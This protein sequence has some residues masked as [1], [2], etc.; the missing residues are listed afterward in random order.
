MSN[1]Q[2]VKNTV[3]NP[4]L[5]KI[6]EIKNSG[7]EFKKLG[8]VGIFYSG[9]S[10][11]NKYDFINGNAKF[12]SY[13]NVFNNME[14][15]LNIN[16]TVKV[17][18][19]ES[20]N[21]IKYADVLFTG[22][23]ETLEESGMSSVVTSEPQDNFYLNSFCFGLR[24]FDNIKILP[25]FSKYLFR[26]SHIRKQ[27]IKC[28]QGVTRYN[29]SKKKMENIEI[30]IPPLEVQ[31]EIVRILDTFTKDVNELIDLLKREQELR[32]K[33]YSYYRDKLL[34]FD[35][36][37]PNVK[38]GEIGKIFRG[39]GITKD[40]IKNV[41][42]PCVR[43]GE[44][45]TKYGIY[46][47][48]CYSYIDEND[49]PNKKYFSY[50]DILFAVTG[51]NVI[52]IGKCTAYIGDEQC[53]AG[54]D[55]IVLTNHNQEPKYLSYALSTTNAIKQK[56]KNK[57][58]NTRVHLSLDEVRNIEIPL[59]PIDTQK[60]IVDILDNFERYTNDLQEGLPAEIEK[61]KKQYAY[62]RDELLKFER[63]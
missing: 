4:L 41:G 56:T 49:V 24:F 32:K 39:S 15:D 44:I 42:T 25:Q 23:S 26:A 3:Q 11:K 33:Q 45:Y 55:M 53:I 12:I 19:N 38:L 9:L 2:E 47:D 17:N 18:E 63:K 30:P 8:E 62:Y 29:L 7:V 14:I 5:N 1:L 31:A 50:G 6:K 57:R 20:Q 61:R 51:E 40:Q 48:K 27:I 54:G 36:D 43:Y 46:F 21:T 60:R 52:D 37:T 16:D 35:G 10:G 34:T 22:S 28:S 58:K 59:P 13:K